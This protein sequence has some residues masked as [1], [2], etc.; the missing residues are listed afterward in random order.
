M[1]LMA[2]IPNGEIL[3][4][5]QPTGSSPVTLGPAVNAAELGAFMAVLLEQNL[6]QVADPGAGTNTLQHVEVSAPTDQVDAGDALLARQ[7]LPLATTT[8]ATLPDAQLPEQDTPEILLPANQNRILMPQ[9]RSA[10]EIR[11]NVSGSEPISATG[12]DENEQTMQLRT[13]LLTTETSSPTADRSRLVLPAELAGADIRD[14][15]ATAGPRSE[16]S[17]NAAAALRGIEMVTA[18][19]SPGI[20]RPGLPMANPTVFS[21]RLNQQIAVMVTNQA[22]FARIA[23]SPAEL[24]PVEIRVSVVG[25]EANI[26]LAATQAATREALE[27][28]MPRLRMAF[29][30]SGIALGSTDVFAQMPGQQERGNEFARSDGNQTGTVAAADAVDG[31]A[32]ESVAATRRV[33]ISLVDTFI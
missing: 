17:I 10:R 28:A 3:G 27:E 16:S 5:L 8:I 19:N 15:S 30:N 1:E 26:Q 2:T 7:V 23:V 9:E 6:A 25:D 21:E 18:N 29:A 31:H 20:E 33:Q 4:A 24:G 32:D 22:Q 14:L 13:P 11:S 12:A